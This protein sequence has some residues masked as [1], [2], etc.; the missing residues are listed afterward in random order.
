MGQRFQVSGQNGL[1]W[2]SIV[3][4]LTGFASCGGG[5]DG[6]QRD[7][8]SQNGTYEYEF[9]QDING[10]ACSTGHRSYK[11]LSA[12]CEGLTDSSQNNNCALEMRKG[13]F[14]QHCSGTFEES[15]SQTDAAPATINCAQG[16][17][18]ETC[19]AHKQFCVIS[20]VNSN[21]DPAVLKCVDR[22]AGCNECE[23]I[24]AAARDSFDGANNCGDGAWLMCYSKTVSS[25]IAFTV[26]CD[27]SF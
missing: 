27:R 4:I 6:N 24:N 21:E 22:P 7:S 1:L 8:Q 16:S 10:V 17:K 26:T 14:K 25:G 18:Q 13:H 3:V 5:S 23:C 9:E 19:D 12:M 11:S 2:V 15:Y 20:T